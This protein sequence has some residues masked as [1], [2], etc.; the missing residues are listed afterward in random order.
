MTLINA[1]KAVVYAV[2]QAELVVRAEKAIVYVVEQFA[3]ESAVEKAVIYTVEQA[4]AT[5]SAKQPETALRP[6][7]RAAATPYAEFGAGTSLSV[8]IVLSDNYTIIMLKP[9]SSFVVRTEMLTMG[10]YVLNE[11]FNQCVIYQGIADWRLVR[12]IKLSM[13]A[14]V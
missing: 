3:I 12:R 13:L 6:I 5:G 4:D 8:G 10:I 9:D 14:R 1:E 2:E 7:Y 11:D